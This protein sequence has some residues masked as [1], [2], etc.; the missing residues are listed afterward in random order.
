MF[1]ILRAALS[2]TAQPETAQTGYRLNQLP[3]ANDLINHD[4]VTKMSFRE[5]PGW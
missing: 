2:V 5:L 3:K 1:R 4:Y